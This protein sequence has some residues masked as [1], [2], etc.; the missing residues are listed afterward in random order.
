MPVI[1]KINRLEK[2]AYKIN[3]NP[4]ILTTYEVVITFIRWYN[5][6]NKIK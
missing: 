6:E 5:K 3:I 4:D 2:G 1:D